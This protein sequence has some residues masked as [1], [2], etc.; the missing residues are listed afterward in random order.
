MKCLPLV[1][2]CSF[3]TMYLKGQ[4]MLP[5]SENRFIHFDKPLY[6]AGE[7]MRMAIYTGVSPTRKLLRLQCI[8]PAGTVIE[9]QWLEGEEYG[10]EA[11]FKL[12]DTLSDGYY[13]IYASEMSESRDDLLYAL[14]VF[15]DSLRDTP[16]VAMNSAEWFSAS[17]RITDPQIQIDWEMDSIYFQGDMAVL[18]FRLL[19]A[20]EE[21]VE[22]ICSLSFADET[23]IPEVY[24]SIPCTGVAPSLV[25]ET[26][27][28]SDML[29]FRGEWL[30]PLHPPFS[31]AFLG[32]QDV[33]ADRLYPLQ[34]EPG[35]FYVEVESYEGAGDFQLINW[36]PFEPYFP[37]FKLRG[38]GKELLRLLQGSQIQR[39][40]PVSYHRRHVIRNYLDGLFRN[41][42]GRARSN[43]RFVPLKN[44]RLPDKLYSIGDY[45]YCR[46]FEAFFKDAVPSSSLVRQD[47]LW[48]LR[49]FSKKRSTPLTN[50]PLYQVEGYFI[51]DEPYF[52]KSIQPADT[53]EL[54]LYT[55]PGT[56][57]AAYAPNLA[58]NGI[59]S[60]WHVDISDLKKKTGLRAL[61]LNGVQRTGEATPAAISIETTPW[62]A[63]VIWKTGLRTDDTGTVS[64]PCRMPGTSAMFTLHVKG[65]TAH[66]IPFDFEKHIM[67]RPDQLKNE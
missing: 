6:F 60:L 28:H 47:S 5:P 20:R 34:P 9:Q 58:G 14:P 23:G 55:E 50:R 24:R 22:A 38:P 63:Q 13:F 11:L 4:V 51:D 41:E 35:G 67:V 44:V 54:R 39:P 12:P 40:F 7:E 32:F 3:L 10:A 42:K 27:L 64:I 61:T 37:A 53:M 56:I 16:S 21:A 48:S 52:L 19:T 49:L 57:S 45:D 59:V 8:N 66:G 1:W 30:D 46:D 33:M 15:Q 62:Q 65:I 31:F 2:F 18:R 17:D 29:R 25:G 43:L 26:Q 36:N